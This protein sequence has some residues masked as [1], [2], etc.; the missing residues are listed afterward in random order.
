MRKWSKEL[1]E[2]ELQLCSEEAVCN[3][4]FPFKQL[5]LAHNLSTQ[6]RFENTEWKIPHATYQNDEEETSRQ[7]F[8]NYGSFGVQSLLVGRQSCYHQFTMWPHSNV[9]SCHSLFST[10]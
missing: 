10:V 4:T 1:H 9:F 2:K 8:E 3:Y 7:G 6:E 5:F